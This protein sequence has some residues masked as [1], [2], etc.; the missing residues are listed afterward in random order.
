MRIVH[1]LAA[2]VVAVVVILMAAMILRPSSASGRTREAP[3]R[4]GAPALSE[5]SE[6]RWLLV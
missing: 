6:S 2:I 5:H 3:H 4:S 1:L